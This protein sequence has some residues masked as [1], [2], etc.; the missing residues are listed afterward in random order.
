MAKLTIMHISDAHWSVSNS[1]EER[2]LTDRLID[3]LGVMKARG[4][5]PDIII[6]SGDLVQAGQDSG[7]F[8]GAY[9]AL[10][11]P[12]LKETNLDN[13][14][15]FVCPG[16]HDISREVARSQSLIEVGLSET[17]NSQDAIAHFVE[18]AEEVQSMESLALQRMDNFYRWH[19]SHFDGFIK[20]S[21]FARLKTIESAGKRVAICLLN[22][23][24]RATGE[25]GDVD[26]GKL[27]LGSIFIDSA[28]RRIE[29]CDYKIAV[30]HH[31]FEYHAEF[32]R[33]VTEPRI[34]KNFDLVCTG[35]THRPKPD[36]VED[37]YGS[38]VRSQAG[39]LYAGSRWFNGYQLIE[40]DF[41]ND[42]TRIY[43][44]EYFGIRDEFDAA[45]NLTSADP[46]ELDFAVKNRANS[47]QVGLFL[48]INRRITKSKL[49]EH[50]NFTQNNDLSD[51]VLVGAFAC[52]KLF[53][54]SAS[55]LD[56]SGNVT[57]AY[58]KKD[59]KEIVALDESILFY[60]QRQTGKTALKLYLAYK[61]AHG[62]DVQEK[63]PVFI[64]VM[65]FTY[66]LY[67]LKRAI[68]SIYDVP[69]KFELEKAVESGSFVLLFEDVGKLDEK[70]LKR[71]DSFINAYKGNRSF[72]FGCPDENSVAKERHFKK[73]LPDLF[74]VGLGELTRS[75]IRKMTNCWFDDSAEAKQSFDLVLTQINRD[76]L[77]RTAYIVSLLLWAA[78][79]GQQGDRLNEAILLQNVLDH[80][81]DRADFRSARRG[82]LTTKGKELLLSR[83]ANCLDGV[84]GSARSMRVIEWVDIYFQQKKL[85]HDA[86]EV[87]GEL[88]RCGILR[89]EEGKISFRYK[90]FQ[91]YFVALG[92]MD[93]TE[94]VSKAE[95][96]KFLLR[97]RE[98]ELLSGLKGDND[99]LI[100]NIQKVLDE[101]M[102]RDLAE[103]NY[104]NFEAL[105][106][107]GVTPFVT[108]E[109]LRK[110]KRTRL[111]EEQIDEV[112]EAIDERATARGDQSVS[113]SIDDAGG[114]IV[115]AAQ[116]RQADAVKK[117]LDEDAKYFRPSTYM[118]G[119]SI[120]S[121]VVRNSDYT[122]YEKKG[123]ALDRILED[124]CRIHVLLT[125][126]ARWVL[127]RLEEREEEKLER[128]D[129][130]TL[131]KIV[132]KMLF[133]VVGGAVVAEVSTPSLLETLAELEKEGS[134]KSGKKILSFLISEDSDDPTWADKWK[135]VIEDKD[136]K[137][138]DIDVLMDRLW[139]A[140]N[141]KALDDEQDRRVL[142]VVDAVE[143]K[144]DWE[145]GQKSTVLEG[146]RDL[147]N[148]KRASE[149]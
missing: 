124:W 40:V 136:A 19:D 46:I 31:P 54:K 80:L 78:K 113:E 138:F 84:D 82:T 68:G 102:P 77:P 118:A 25:A 89:R 88:I 8:E 17:L 63:I 135:S 141:R 29:K 27:L 117:D 69:A 81:L 26:H 139:R 35:H 5:E 148:V 129:F 60:G 133:G 74:M 131:V 57:E 50:L 137:A 146:I 96:R 92:M 42:K 95:G 99:W 94:L 62:V 4:V 106:Y 58:S 56:E 2:V 85:K 140:V 91:E 59:L 6:F 70:G 98:V 110:I 147:T 43:C 128:Q 100:A 51:E 104:A 103:V 16:N 30:F 119:V 93:H 130:E 67:G 65:D 53:T 61:Y 73:L 79:Q 116:S 125:K 149:D 107:E 13:S 36:R 114:D 87:V 143:A 24:W 134:I 23:A 15:V 105:A 108:R 11:A 142:K 75:S 64:D 38:S 145:K 109:K 49:L 66:N 10:L 18:A 122:D 127:E 97:P 32:D 123:P 47:D 112:M 34:A 3:D 44:R 45:A 33:A 21:R 83:L 121:R 41:V 14:S 86:D 1:H 37:I 76:G 111:T 55:K 120:L 144:F 9:K 52:P 90:C 132:S 20:A 101:G 71:L 72:V 7:S 12:I 48:D 126:E 39:S 22:S 115:Q 28:I